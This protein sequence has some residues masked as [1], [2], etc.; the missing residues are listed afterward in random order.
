MALKDYSDNEAVRSRGQDLVSKLRRM[1]TYDIHSYQHYLQSYTPALFAVLYTS[2][3][4]SPIYQRYLQSY[5]YTISSPT[6]TICGPVY[7]HY[8]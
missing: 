2:P 8:L 3:I 1:L 6:N 7:Q 4:C 5:T